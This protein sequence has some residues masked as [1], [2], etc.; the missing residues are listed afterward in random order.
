MFLC[1]IWGFA[2][3]RL[4]AGLGRCSIQVDLLLLIVA[5][6]VCLPIIS[7]RLDAAVVPAIGCV[8]IGLAIGCELVDMCFDSL[9]YWDV[10]LTDGDGVISG[11]KVAFLY[12]NTM[13]KARHINFSI[14][15]FLLVGQ[16]GALVGL[17]RSPPK[18][19]QAWKGLVAT[20][21]SGNGGYL[22]SVVPRY[23]GIRFATEFDEGFF[24]GWSWVIAARF[25]LLVNLLI[26]IGLLMVILS[27]TQ[28]DKLHT[29]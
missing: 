17:T 26:A 3:H 25:Y 2:I 6:V 29:K 28:A 13:L 20:M 23:L 18:V 10:T 11:R 7:P 24:D 19:R 12:Y 8:V 14:E 21:I 9:I 27:D 5:H 22:T 4:T 16:F 15:L 1:D